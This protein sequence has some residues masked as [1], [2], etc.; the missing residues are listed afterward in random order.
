MHVIGRVKYVKFVKP[1]QEHSHLIRQGAVTKFRSFY[2]IRFC[3]P[4]CISY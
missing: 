2:S 1:Y 4:N 3:M